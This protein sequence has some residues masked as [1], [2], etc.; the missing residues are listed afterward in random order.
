M[1]KKI[2]KEFAKNVKAALGDRTAYWLSKESGV[3][4]S[5][6]S[7]ILSAEQT[8]SL[9]TVETLAFALGVEPSV[10]ISKDKK[11]PYDIPAD[12]LEML[13]GRDEYV[14]DAVRSLLRAVDRRK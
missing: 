4:A 5:T 6:L 12:V 7:R 10:L 13:E 8:A 3:A 9:D 11:R 2:S 14:I 1:S